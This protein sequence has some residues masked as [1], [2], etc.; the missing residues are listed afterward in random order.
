MIMRANTK[1]PIVLATLAY[2]CVIASAG[3]AFTMGFIVYKI[4]ANA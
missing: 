1:P 4:L 3:M 2:L